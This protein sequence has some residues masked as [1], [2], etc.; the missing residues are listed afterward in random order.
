MV[1]TIL[2]LPLLILA[3]D[4][5]IMP[6]GAN[7]TRPYILLLVPYVLSSRLRSAGL[8]LRLTNASYVEVRSEQV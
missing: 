6:L 1:L 3:F 4:L 5:P 7:I 8:F 2:I